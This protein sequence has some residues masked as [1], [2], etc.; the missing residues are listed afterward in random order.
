MRLPFPIAL[1]FRILPLSE[2]V[3]RYLPNRS[4]YMIFFFVIEKKNPRALPL[5]CMTEEAHPK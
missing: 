4:G 1:F 5:L 3:G 2:P